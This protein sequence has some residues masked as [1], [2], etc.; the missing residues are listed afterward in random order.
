MAVDPQNWDY[1]SLRDQALYLVR[2]CDGVD[3]VTSQ[4]NL[5]KWKK[6][7]TNDLWLRLKKKGLHPITVTHYIN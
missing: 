5:N 4:S 2:G 1:V 7:T 3:N 6:F